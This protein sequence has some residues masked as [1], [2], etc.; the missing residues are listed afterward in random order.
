MTLAMRKGANIKRLHRDDAY[1]VSFQRRGTRVQLWFGDATY[2]GRGNA[3][4]EANKVIRAIK[5]LLEAYD[6]EPTPDK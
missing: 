3:W 2:G 6:N 4:R 1:H 5:K